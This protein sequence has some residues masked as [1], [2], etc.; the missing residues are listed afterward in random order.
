MSHFT[1]R[2]GQQ[3]IVDSIT[4]PHCQRRRILSAR[5]STRLRQQYW[6]EKPMLYCS[7]ACQEAHMTRLMVDVALVFPINTQK[8][9]FERLTLLTGVIP[10]TIVRRLEE[11]LL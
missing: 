6:V 10:E 5:E 9:K 3:E 4:C 1:L 2:S 7:L 8:A 11:G